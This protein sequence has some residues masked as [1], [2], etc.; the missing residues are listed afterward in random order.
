MTS[1]IYGPPLRR[2]PTRVV[3]TFWLFAA[4]LLFAA[5]VAFIGASRVDPSHYATRSAFERARDLMYGAGV[6][7][8]FLIPVVV[9][10]IVAGRV[11]LRRWTA[12]LLLVPV[13]NVGLWVRI[14]WRLTSLPYR[15]WA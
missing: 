9:L 15:P 7:V 1:F 2:I 12:L 11:G 5:E 4:Q 6:G 14:L 3:W 8:Y 10:L 13:L